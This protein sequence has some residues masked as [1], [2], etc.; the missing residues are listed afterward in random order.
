MLESVARVF[1]AATDA[2]AFRELHVAAKSLGFDD[3]SCMAAYAAKDSGS[4]TGHRLEAALHCGS[5][6]DAWLTYLFEQD[7][8]QDDYDLHRFLCGERAPYASGLGILDWMPPVEP[9]HRVMLEGQARLGYGPKLVVPLLS[10]PFEPVSH[11]A[12][13]YL[14]VLS[15]EDFVARVSASFPQLVGLANAFHAR[16]GGDVHGFLEAHGRRRETQPRA[17]IS[18]SNGASPL[19][20]RQAQVL[21]GLSRGER[22]IAI[23]AELKISRA[24]VDRHVVAAREALGAQTVPE[25]VA[26]A[27]SKGWIR[28]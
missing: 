14:S 23:A 19:S 27:V 3:V 22:I 6:S 15:G 13:M 11:A 18:G 24:T 16:L 26:L 2:D 12:L 20:R 7:Q 28:V 17:G 21:I 1:G 5:G 25:A 10:S 9:R 4:P 8:P